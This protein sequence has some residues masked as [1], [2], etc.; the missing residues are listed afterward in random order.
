MELPLVFP[1]WRRSNFGANIFHNSLAI[2][3][4]SILQGIGVNDMGLRSSRELGGFVLGIGTVI[5]RFHRSGTTPS[6]MEQLKMSQRGVASSG[7]NS[8]S[9]LGGMSSGPGDLLFAILL[10]L[11]HVVFA[12]NCL[13]RARG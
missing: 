4:S 6:V 3:L 8:R 2:I 7:A 9:N 13:Q 1:N 5:A 10:V 12:D 11:V